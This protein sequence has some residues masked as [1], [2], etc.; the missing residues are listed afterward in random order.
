MNELETI[1]IGNDSFLGHAVPFPGVTTAE[2]EETEHST[3]RVPSLTI[4]GK[5]E[6][7]G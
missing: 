3:N 1:D 7:E 2:Q 4:A 6:K 5:S